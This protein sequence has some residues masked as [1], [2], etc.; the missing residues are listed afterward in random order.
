MGSGAKT[1]VETVTQ[2]VAVWSQQGANM[3][4]GV[5]RVSKAGS[6]VTDTC[7]SVI[8]RCGVGSVMIEKS[9]LLRRKREEG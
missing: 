3:E 8:E 4:V 5:W 6:E 7:L 1:G 9:S 2:F